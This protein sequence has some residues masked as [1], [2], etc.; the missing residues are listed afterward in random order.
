MTSSSFFF[1][2]CTM[3]ETMFFSF[4]VTIAYFYVIISSVY[5]TKESEDNMKKL[6]VLLL[7]ALSST[8]LMTGCGKKE[9]ASVPEQSVVVET[10]SDVTEPEEVVEEVEEDLPPEE[11]L[12]RSPL[13]NEWV[14]EEAA[15]LR[16]LAVMI[17][18]DKGAL[19][20]YNISNADILY[21]CMVEGNIT[22]LMAV[23]SDWKGLER[24]GNVRSC[25]DYYVYWAFEWDAIYIHCGGPF[26][27]DDVIGRP[28]TQNINEQVSPGG[29]F[30][31]SNDRKAP[32]NLYF[33]G[34]DIY[35][36]AT[37]LG[38]PL[39]AREDKID[40]VHF[41]FASEKTPNTLEQYEDSVTAKKIDLANAYP[42]SQ[43]WFEYNEEDGLYYRFQKPSGGAHIDAATDTQ[44]A[45]KNVLVQFAYYEVRDAKGYLAFQCI[46]DTRDGWY[47]TNGKGI[48][49][50]WEKTS[51]YGS[52]RFYDDNGNEINLNTGKTMICIVQDGKTFA[53]ED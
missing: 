52:T 37:R 3:K 36:E 17:P 32:Q 9:E 42:T 31:R 34:T 16:P 40:S 1:W 27:I 19:P 6:S 48:H 10:P 39:E 23:F 7:I 46:D 49:V 14:S 43:T 51:N 47:F 24:V 50:N 2:L 29:V 21:E 13:T 26:Y 18:N 41:Q 53:Y 38:Y 20:H 35:D 5:L 11:G 28:D 12:V 45:F 30:F 8:L 4:L 44:L 25:R 15:A 33:N 22:R